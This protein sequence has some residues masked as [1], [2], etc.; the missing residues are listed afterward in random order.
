MQFKF[1]AVHVLK[2]GSPQEAHVV[3]AHFFAF[4]PGASQQA[5]QWSNVTTA[6]HSEIHM[7]TGEYR[8]MQ[9]VFTD[10][11]QYLVQAEVQ[12]HVRGVGDRLSTAPA[13]WSPIHP[14]A[15]SITSPAEWYTF[16]V[17][18]EDDLS[19]TLAHTDE[20]P[21]A[22]A[23]TI[24]DSTASFTVTATNTGPE[25]AKDAIVQVR[26]PQG[27]TYK[28]GSARVGTAT[29]APPSSVFNYGCGVISWQL[30]RFGNYGT[31]KEGETRTASP[32]TLTFTADVAS[33]PDPGGRLTA[34]AEIRNADRQ[35]VDSD[36]GNDTSSA[37]VLRSSTAVRPPFFESG[38]TRSIPENAVAGAYIDIP[39]AVN[40]D[41]R[42]LT[43]SLSGP[44]T[45]GTDP[46]FKINSGT[47]RIV[48][49]KS[50]DYRKQW[51]FPLTVG[52]S[53]GV[54]TAGAADKSAD[55]SFP[56]LVQVT[57]MPAGAAPVSVTFTRSRYQNNRHPTDLN[58][59]IVNE[60]LGITP[61]LHNLPP[62]VENLQFGWEDPYGGIP[63]WLGNGGL[64]PTEETPGTHTY[65]LHIRWTGSNEPG[66]YS[67]EITVTYSVEWFPYQPDS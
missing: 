65:T 39:A 38:V 6:T 64:A 54:N 10:P 21:T 25:D 22:D 40:P 5:P 56:V 23:T 17:G 46:W 8:H 47:G 1:V 57:D 27:L 14:G 18:P 48:L 26:L 7:F 52:V 44:C 29:T 3:G 30:G 58:R 28:A 55:D 11:G 13:N 20:T 16:H 66:S 12:G 37:T 19:V 61:H 50:L 41:G 4:D 45:E 51:A 49:A 42:T 15:E 35:A 59:P 36:P 31:L 33:S 67:A 60:T 9:Y 24:T 34:T 63:F 62:G 53:D 32:A 43:Y 2:D